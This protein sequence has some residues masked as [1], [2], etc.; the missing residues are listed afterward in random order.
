M[1]VLGLRILVSALIRV[2]KISPP[3]A[4]RPSWCNQ[5]SLIQLSFC[6]SEAVGPPPEQEERDDFSR[7]PDDDQEDH[8]TLDVFIQVVLERALG[9]TFWPLDGPGP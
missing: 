6:P 1:Q 7:E 2:F 4:A 5:A 3:G 9:S 8:A